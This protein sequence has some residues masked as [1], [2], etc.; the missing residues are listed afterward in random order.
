MEKPDL[1][2]ERRVRD[3]RSREIS[4]LSIGGGG[5][6][7]TL[8]LSNLVMHSSTVAEWMFAR[9]SLYLPWLIVLVS[10]EYQF[11]TSS[12]YCRMVCLRFLLEGGATVC[13]LP[14]CLSL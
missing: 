2:W 1:N 3:F 6:S 12:L 10:L 7:R 4:S 9:H 14:G 5:A 13:F 8:F 11:S